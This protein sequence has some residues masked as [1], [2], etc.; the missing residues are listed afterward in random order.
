MDE[1]GH[2]C[3]LCALPKTSDEILAEIDD[4][5]LCIKQKLIDCCR[6][7]QL[8]ELANEKFPINVCISCIQLLEQ[9]WEFTEFV[10]ESQHRL[11]EIIEEQTLATGSIPMNIQF[12]AK[13][14]DIDQNFEQNFNQK[15]D[16]DSYQDVCNDTETDKE[17]IIDKELIIPLVRCDELVKYYTNICQKPKIQQEDAII[18]RENKPIT[19][20]KLTKL[21]T[22]LNVKTEARKRAPKITL[23]GHLNGS[24]DKNHINKRRRKRRFIKPNSSYQVT[25]TGKQPSTMK[26]VRRTNGT[27]GTN[28]FDANHSDDLTYEGI[29]EQLIADDESIN[30]GKIEEIEVFEYEQ[31]IDSEQAIDDM[32]FEAEELANLNKIVKVQQPKKKKKQ[33]FAISKPSD[34]VDSFIEL[35]KPDDLNE[36]GTINNKRIIELD[37]ESWMV[38]QHQCYICGDIS[39]DYGRLKTHF[40]TE[41]P[42]ETMRHLCSLCTE[43]KITYCRRHILLRHIIKEHYLHLTHWSVNECVSFVLNIYLIWIF[44]FFFFF[45]VTVAINV[46]HFIGIF[47]NCKSI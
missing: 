43:S 41:H 12:E 1:L 23:N 40:M 8:E 5:A 24:S 15:F 44:L 29:V 33:R 4:A 27:N 10:A 28:D 30:V 26:T 42:I 46:I 20:A 37:L 34:P 13:H 35:F 7:N 32:G 38:L 9:C 22:T 3:R 2:F 36:D 14:F 11:L 21:N 19:D 39:V 47:R 17:T 18:A 45:L 25:V 31:D 6:W 16:H